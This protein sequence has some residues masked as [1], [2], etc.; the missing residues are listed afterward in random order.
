MNRKRNVIVILL[1]LIG[2]LLGGAVSG[3]LLSATSTQAQQVDEAGSG[4]KWEYCGLMKAAYVASS[5]GGMYWI[6]YFRDTG[7]QVV[8][9]QASATDGSGGAM[10]KA[11]SRLGAEG[12][13]M[14]GQGPIEIS[15]GA[16][17][18]IYFKRLKQPSR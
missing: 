1:V 6:V 10:G 16:S 8:D 13:E 7:V 2:G 12:W 4:Q 17:N 3:Q 9:V 15:Q 18:A 5:R 14:V 11:L